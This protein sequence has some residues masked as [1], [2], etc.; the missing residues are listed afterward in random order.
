[1]K[2]IGDKDEQDSSFANQGN[3]EPLALQWAK[4]YLQNLDN[5]L[6][7]KDGADTT[8]LK[9]VV[10][11]EGRK[12][13][14]QRLMALLPTVSHQSWHQVETLLSKEIKRHQID[15]TLI[16][17]WEITADSFKIY[18]KILDV[19]TQQ[20]PL[21]QLSTVMRLAR[22][23]EPL[24]QKAL[25]I[26]T[27]Q[28]APSQLAR[29]IG[30]HVGAL[31]NKYTQQ[32]PRILGFVGMQFHYTSKILLQSLS[33]L[34]RLVL[35]VYFKVL[36]DHLYMPLQRLYE[37]AANHDYN[38]NTLVAVQNLLPV[39]TEIAKKISEKIIDYYPNYRCY[40]GILSHPLVKTSSI[41]DVEMFQVYLW[42]A[43]L[44]G[45]IS[46]IKQELFPLS[47]MLYPTLNVQWEIIRQMLNLLGQEIKEHLTPK[48]SDTIMP[49]YQALWH[50]FSPE[51]F[52]EFDFCQDS[53]HFD[54]DLSHLCLLKSSNQNIHL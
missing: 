24:Y 29:V 48:Q 36:D 14:A 42:L 1:M 40:S 19:Y 44:E 43:T 17:P 35:I 52:V 21:R 27:E 37:A 26:Y 50:M 2:K 33:E 3:T 46:A 54:D 39:S 32:D 22:Q 25:E 51:V 30:S 47:V 23:G 45:N 10:S 5:N 6:W 34:E 13:T 31:R 15:P 49:Y 11:R 7:E 16:N 38:S 4:K 20:A 28:V 12:K 9:E 41:R 53:H 8:S 18:E